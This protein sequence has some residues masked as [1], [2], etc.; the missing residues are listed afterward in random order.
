MTFY[1]LDMNSKRINNTQDPSGN[2]D[3][4]TKNYV[5]TMGGRILQV[6]QGTTSTTST[7]QSTTFVTTG[8]SATITP[9][10]ASSKVLIQVQIPFG[11]NNQS[12][13]SN[14]VMAVFR[15]TVS[16]TLL[17]G[18]VVESYISSDGQPF[19]MPTSITFLDTPATTSPQLY[20]V[21]FQVGSSLDTAIVCQN[22]RQAN[23]VL[24]EVR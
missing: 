13:F 8:L 5:D 16:G 12:V 23:I 7:T 20:T 1:D 3:V 14:P 24:M 19:S 15:G 4:A 18:T 22:G 2:Q 11:K 10:S 17:T 9:S 6:V 21:A